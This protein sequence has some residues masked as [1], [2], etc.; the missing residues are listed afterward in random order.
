MYYY[1]RF[2]TNYENIRSKIDKSMDSLSAIWWESTEPNHY[3][4]YLSESGWYYDRVA[5]LLTDTNDLDTGN[6][7]RLPWLSAELYYGTV[8]LADCSEWVSGLRYK[9][10]DL[11][12]DV[13]LQVW[14][15]ENTHK[16]NKT[17]LAAY[18]FEI[19]DENGTELRI[20][21]GKVIA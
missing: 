1:N 2:H 5:K 13:I 17:D 7:K 9:G 14:A 21:L 12:T 18:R 8:K 4:N 15:S 16:I 19:I 20:G 11:T 10:I 3:S 6:N